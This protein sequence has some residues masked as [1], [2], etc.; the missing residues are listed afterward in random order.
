MRLS[1]L[2]VFLARRVSFESGAF[3]RCDVATVARVARDC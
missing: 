1:Y 3:M 2:S